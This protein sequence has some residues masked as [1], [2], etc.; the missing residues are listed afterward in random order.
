MGG[1]FGSLGARRALY[2]RGVAPVN[3]MSES[4]EQARTGVS[5]PS[6]SI[7]ADVGTCDNVSSTISPRW[8]GRSWCSV[9]DVFFKELSRLF[10]SPHHASRRAVWYISFVGERLRLRTQ[11]GM[12]LVAARINRLLKTISARR[13][14]AGINTFVLLT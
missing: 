12:F 7:K 5:P 6:A 14:K 13:I 11:R 1:L 10:W 2:Q 9:T 4:E 8:H 3:L